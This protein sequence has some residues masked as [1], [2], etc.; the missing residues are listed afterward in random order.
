MVGPQPMR[1]AIRP[2]AGGSP[3]LLLCNGIGAPLEA[4]ESFTAALD[5][6]VE[7]VRFDV[8]GVGGSP[9]RRLPYT[10][11]GLA[12]LAGRMLSQLGYDRFDVL[13]FSW[14]GGSPSNSRSRTH[15]AAGGWSWCP[16]RPAA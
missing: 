13:G 8:P 14:G 5:P 16:P 9:V 10:F 15:G 6:A 1:V 12:R 7:V 2:G 3:P 11:P 4:V